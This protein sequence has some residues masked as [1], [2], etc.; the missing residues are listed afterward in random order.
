MPS[1]SS[2][3]EYSYKYRGWKFPT[4]LFALTTHEAIAEAYEM[5]SILLNENLLLSALN[6]PVESAGGQDAYYYFFEKVAALGY[7]VIANHPFQDGNKRLGLLLMTQTLEW[8]GYYL[9]WSEET[10]VYIIS[11][12]GAGYLEQ[13]G[14]RHALVL[15]CGLDP[16]D[17]TH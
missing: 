12:V 15:A 9:Q 14:L 1:L 6:A 11:L 13:D 10:A 3:D 17:P 5:D 2:K 16:A 8:N 4:P 7:R